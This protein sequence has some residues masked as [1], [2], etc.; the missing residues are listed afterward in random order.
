MTFGWTR[1]AKGT[2]S[3]QRQRSSPPECSGRRNADP[4]RASIHEVNLRGDVDNAAFV[5]HGK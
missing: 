5:A 2:V 3:A 1:G 4:G